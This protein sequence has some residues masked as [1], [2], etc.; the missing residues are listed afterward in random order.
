MKILIVVLILITSVNSFANAQS[1][2][3]SKGQGGFGIGGGFANNDE[4]SGFSAAIGF[5]ASGVFDLGLSISRLG[6]EQ[7]IFDATVVTP[8]T[9][10]FLVK[11]DETMPASINLS[12]AYS[13]TFYST[14]ELKPS[15]IDLKESAFSIGVSLQSLID[16]T[17]NFGIQPFMRFSYGKGKVTVVTP[18]S[19]DVYDGTI[20]SLG[21]STI[22]RNTEKSIVVLEPQFAFSNKIRT[23]GLSLNYI[24][25]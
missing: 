22:F 9:S 1:A 3:L 23:F 12:A 4:V 19:E 8:Y 15:D 21:L 13:R 20:F 11:Q 7:M 16:F 25:F 5:S 17:D 6:I 14:E 10:V 18:P 2:Y 24:F